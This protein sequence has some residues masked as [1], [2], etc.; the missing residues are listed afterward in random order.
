[1]SS[2]T[3]AGRI[4]VPYKVVRLGAI[5]AAVNEVGKALRELVAWVPG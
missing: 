5:D 1:M 4:S 2:T 3:S